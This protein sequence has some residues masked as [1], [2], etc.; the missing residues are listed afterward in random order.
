MSYATLEQ[1]TTRFG[2]ALLLQLTDRATPPAGAIDADV[3]ARALADTDAAIDGYLAGRYA[4]PLAA[5]PALLVPIALALAIY[6]LHPFTP[7]QKIADD[8]KAAVADLD[9]I[10]KGVIRLAAPGPSGAGGEPQGSAVSG[11]ETI[12]R[13]RELT[14]ESMSGFI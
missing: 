5:T 6:A 3:V 12:D 11:V 7:E 4:L 8:Y 9:R 10:A 13:E 1:L 2:E 14:P